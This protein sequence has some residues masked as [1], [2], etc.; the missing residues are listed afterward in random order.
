VIENARPSTPSIPKSQGAPAR[1]LAAQKQS[2]PL[3]VPQHILEDDMGPLPDIDPAPDEEGEITVAEF[4]P[5]GGNFGATSE[6]I[7]PQF[8][9]GQSKRDQ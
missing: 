2:A 9:D 4:V 3:H 5:M 8:D 6:E 7:D 1:P